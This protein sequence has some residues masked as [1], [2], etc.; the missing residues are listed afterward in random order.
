MSTFVLVHGSWHGAWCWYKVVPR[1]KQAGH[2]VIAPDLPSL[3]SDKTPISNITPRTWADSIGDILVSQVEPVVLV[4]H[5]RGGMVISQVAEAM[6]DK[7]DT[8]VYLSAFLLRNGES[9][10]EVAQSEANADSL[11]PANLVIDE[12]V[13][14]LTVRDEAIQKAFYGSCTVEDV[15]LARLL[16][17]PEAIAP[18]AEPIH[19]TSARFDSVRRIFIECSYDNALTPMLQKAMYKAVPCETVKSIDT[20][21][22]PF[23]SAPDELVRQLVTEVVLG[24]SFR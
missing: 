9:A 24:N 4:G 10:L 22:S 5:S 17:Q 20:D 11:V 23:F 15:E 21:H 14:S 6:P 13:G 12:S 2:H 8:L 7:I 16:L 3:G 1:L 19:T 18:L